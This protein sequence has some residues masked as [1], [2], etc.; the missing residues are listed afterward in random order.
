MP[1]PAATRLTRLIAPPYAL[2]SC[3]RALI[4]RSTI[5]SPLIDPRDRYN[6]SPATPLCTIAWFVEGEGELVVPGGLP[7]APAPVRAVFAGPQTQPTT[8]W[9]PGPVRL[10][11]VMFYPQALQAVSG[12]DM[13][14]WVDRW[15]PLDQV[16]GLE[17]QPLSAAILGAPDDAARLALLE[18]FLAPRWQAARPRGAGAAAGDWVRHLAWQAADTAMGRSVRNIER[19]I[20]ARAGQ[21]MRSLLRLRRAEQ[22][23]FDAREQALGGGVNLAD[24]A[25]QGGYADQAHLSREVREITGHSPGKFLRLLDSEDESYWI[26]RIWV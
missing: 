1:N 15:A 10:F 23:F 16:L 8:S 14:A 5:E 3:V 26:Y 25:A 24:V 21:S 7:P 12:I 18:Q 11:M 20:K 17:W 19:R 22:S 2:S 9:N 13:A 4:T 6:H